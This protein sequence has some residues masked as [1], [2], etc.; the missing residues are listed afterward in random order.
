MREVDRTENSLD[1]FC[2]NNSISIAGSAWE[3]VGH[4]VCVAFSSPAAAAAASSMD[5]SI[6]ACESPASARGTSTWFLTVV[7]ESSK[8][9]VSDIFGG[10]NA[11]SNAEDS[12]LVSEYSFA[13]VARNLLSPMDWR[14][15]GSMC[16]STLGLSFIFLAFWWERLLCRNTA[17]LCTGCGCEMCNF[18]L[19]DRFT[20]DLLRFRCKCLIVCAL[21]LFDTGP[22]SALSPPQ[23]SVCS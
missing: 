18:R 23:S 16:D 1:S 3:I 2:L 6:V 15:I 11:V 10:S 14:M 8:S 13:S 5:G 17:L 12:G 22:S 4:V 7:F 19:V 21:S 20:A 9:S